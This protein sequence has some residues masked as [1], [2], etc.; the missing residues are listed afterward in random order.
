MVAISVLFAVSC[1]APKGSQRI[2]PNDLPALYNSAV[3]DAAYPEKDE[4]YK[5]L[6]SI[7]PDN[8]DLTWK[9]I[10]GEQY[11][12]MVS[13]KS[14]RTYYVN[15]PKKGTYNTKKWPIWVTA[16][17]QLLNRMKQEKAADVNLRLEQLL[18][19]PPTNTYKWF[20][21]FWVKPADL[22]R[23]CPDKEINDTQCDWCG[24]GDTTSAHAKWMN[25]TRADRYYACDL[26][27]KYP[28][29]QLGYT[30]DWNAGNKS[31]VGL[32]EFVIKPF[33]EVVI[34]KIYATEDYLKQ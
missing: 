4:V 11:V 24:Y 34:E 14:D 13:W 9:T 28:W 16:A 10:K 32:S 7:S 23:P 5:G 6:V 33:R 12:L 29:T 26:Y 27:K 8:K 25:K 18:G 19:L 1:V 30:Y 17:P 22:F 31:H 21:E 2:S 20:V 3:A 15:D